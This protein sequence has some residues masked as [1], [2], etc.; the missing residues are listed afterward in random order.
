MSPAFFSHRNF[1]ERVMYSLQR[2]QH[3]CY[4][5]HIESDNVGKIGITSRLLH[6]LKNI[7]QALYKPHKVYLIHCNSSQESLKLE[8]HL[9]K[10]LTHKHVSG[11]WFRDIDPGLIQSMLVYPDWGHLLLVPQGNETIPVAS[12]AEKPSFTIQLF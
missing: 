12:E 5:I 10:A 3:Y 8:R 9:H 2:K 11:E 1:K 7:R 6:R 4:L